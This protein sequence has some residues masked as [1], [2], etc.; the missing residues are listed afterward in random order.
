[1]HTQTHSCAHTSSKLNNSQEHEK[2]SFI[3]VYYMPAKCQ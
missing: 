2:T 3:D 1:M